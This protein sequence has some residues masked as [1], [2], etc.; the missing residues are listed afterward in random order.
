MKRSSV[1]LKPLRKKLLGLVPVVLAVVVVIFLVKTKSGP[2]RKEIQETTRMMRV[3]KVPVVDLVPRTSGYGVAE[4]DQVWRAVAEVRGRVAE[5]HPELKSGALVTKGEQLLKIDPAE[6]E[7]RIAEIQANI[8]AINTEITELSIQEKNTAASLKI[9]N[10]S[11]QLAEQSLARKKSVLKDNTIAPYEFEQEERNVLIQRQRVQDL[12]NFVNLLPARLQTLQ[13]K[14]A[15]ADSALAQARLDLAKTVI[16]APFD[17]RIAEVSIEPDQYLAAGQVLFE[18]HG[19]AVT[20]VEAQVP[21]EQL[22]HLIGPGAV[23]GPGESLFISAMQRLADIRAIVRIRS[24]NWHI[25]WEARVDRLREAVDP[26]TRAFNVV[27]AVDNPYEKVI[28]GR[29]PPLARGL[30]CEV[31]LQGPARPASIV[32][33][34]SGLHN[35]TVYIL[36]RENRLQPVPV[37]VDYFQGDLAVIGAGLAGGETLVVSDPTPAISGMLVTPEWDGELQEWVMHEAKA[38]RVR[39]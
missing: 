23:P 19:T 9:E 30:F 28:P 11:L 35:S 16:R 22:R 34:R 38:E 4:P 12:E 8:A 26:E 5:V 18:A 21:G 15:A 2:I 25:E 37:A 33:P 1:T 32:I 13:A 7:L 39:R 31:E 3:L 10:R 14:L 24:G 36:D 20:E 6:Y 17:C 29:R 27:V